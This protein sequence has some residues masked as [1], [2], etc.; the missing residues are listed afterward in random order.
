MTG[1]QNEINGPPVLSRDNGLLLTVPSHSWADS[2]IDV[3]INDTVVPRFPLRVPMDW[4]YSETDP[5]EIYKLVHSP[6]YFLPEINALWIKA[7]ES[8]IQL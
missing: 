5:H 6:K 1:D 3:P 8:L 7:L 2:C 4:V